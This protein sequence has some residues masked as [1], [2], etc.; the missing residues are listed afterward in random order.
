MEKE[1]IEKLRTELKP[2]YENLIRDVADEQPKEKAFFCMQWGKNFPN[3][4]NKGILFVGRAT[5]GWKDHD[6]NSDSFFGT[7][8]GQLF[9]LNDQMQWVEDSEGPGNDY[10]TNSSPFW[11]V[12]RAVTQEYHPTNWSSYVAWTNV[13]KVAPWVGGNPSE[14]LY[15]A[16]IKDCED[17]FKK[18]VEALSP[19][20][21]VFLTSYVWAK[22]I[23]TS[24]NNSIAP[25][26]IK[27]VDWG[28]KFNCKTY[29]LN[30]ISCIVTEHPQGK[31]EKEHVETLIN[32]I[33]KL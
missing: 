21:I 19:K 20:V 32:A 24:L 14:S 1:Q 6:Y 12:V 28:D 5:N 17:I 11:R 2:L 29:N 22:D 16:E 30:G 31:P 15:Q 3:E 8:Y 23:L 7:G 27:S 25:K 26:E 4:P 33:N 13:C 18:E 10:N 9:N